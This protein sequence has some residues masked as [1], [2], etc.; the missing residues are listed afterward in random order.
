MPF[1]LPPGEFSVPLGAKKIGFFFSQFLQKLA[2]Y[3]TYGD[4][5]PLGG[6]KE[7]QML[8]EVVFLVRWARQ[9]HVEMVK[10]RT[11][12]NFGTLLFYCLYRLIHT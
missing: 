11:T 5:F 8:S 6:A 12:R 3:T 7:R 4:F 1:L 10:F 9:N 2:R